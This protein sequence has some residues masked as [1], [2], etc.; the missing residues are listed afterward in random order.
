MSD[1]S[2]KRMRQTGEKGCVSV[3][4]YLYVCCHS[5]VELYGCLVLQRQVQVPDEQH[6]QPNGERH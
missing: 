4:A 2:R 1:L 6:Y 5:L 3:K